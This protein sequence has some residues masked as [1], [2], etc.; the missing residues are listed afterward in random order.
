MSDGTL[1]NDD[2]FLARVLEN[3]R[4]LKDLHLPAEHKF[5]VGDM[6]KIDGVI[7]MWDGQTWANNDTVYHA[8]PV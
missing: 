5:F 3:L 7:H 1:L 4:E 2:R 8:G 6:V